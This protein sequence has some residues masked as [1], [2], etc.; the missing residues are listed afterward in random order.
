MKSSKSLNNGYSLLFV[1]KEG[2]TPFN[3]LR[4]KRSQRS[5]CCFVRSNLDL[6]QQHWDA[7]GRN[8]IWLRNPSEF[9]PDDCFRVKTG[10]RRVTAILRDGIVLDSQITLE[11]A[12]SIVKFDPISDP[13]GIADEFFK[14]WNQYWQRDDEEDE[15][16]AEFQR[17]LQTLPS[18]QP[19]D[20]NEL[21]FNDWSAALSS[22]KKQSMRGA[23]GWAIGEL[24]RVPCSSFLLLRK[25]FSHAEAHGRWPSLM[26]K[27][28]VI[29][30]PKIEGSLS[31][32][33]VRPISVASMLYRVYARVRTKQILN[34]V[35]PKFLPVPRPLSIGRRFWTAYSLRMTLKG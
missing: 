20:F 25:I 23:D 1:K 11:E 4:R 24:R 6:S 3:A 31:W 5:T 9:R 15:P 35:P 10:V 7:N 30:L 21:S 12:K 32:K 28:W 13:T 2:E 22:A 18:W 19:M 29:L 27:T 8:H 16:S 14:G 26:T 34:R 33:E 17:W